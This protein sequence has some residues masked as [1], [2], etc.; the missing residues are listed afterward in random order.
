MFGPERRFDDAGSDGRDAD[1]ASADA[2][3]VEGSKGADEAVDAVFG[4]VV[5][6]G[7]ERRHLA[8]YAGDVD[9][10]FAGEGFL[11]GVG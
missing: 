5:D 7:V 4:C 8:G 6:G 3:V 10:G 2:G 11:F 1:A 9:D